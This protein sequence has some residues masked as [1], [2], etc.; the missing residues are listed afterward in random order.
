MKIG[1][2]GATGFIG[3]TLGALAD[4]RGHE[5]VAYTRSPEKANLPWAS[6]VRPVD[7]AAALPLDASGLDVL[8]NLAGESIMGRW[9]VEKKKRIRASRI[10]FTQKVARCLAGASPRPTAFLS[11]S[12]VG[13]Y[14]ARGDESLPETA[15]RGMGLLADVC[16]E[17]EAA[18]RRAEQ[19]G[20]RV[21]LLRTGVVLGTEGGAFKLMRRAYAFGLGGRLGGGAQWMPWIHLRDE[22]RLILWAAEHADFHGPLILVAPAAVTNR[23]FTREL[24]AVLRRPACL[25]VPKFALRLVLGE[26]AGMVLGSE[27]AVPQAALLRGFE[28]EQPCLDDAL[29]ALVG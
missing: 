25:H 23:E 7:V 5:V 14:G 3:G 22:A 8:V 24:A 9:S 1:I 11:G 20:L 28:F 21:V 27:R 29:K 15:G 6:E 13:Y 18:A 10:E 2:T 17:W 16:V 4:E 12:A 19:M 26:A